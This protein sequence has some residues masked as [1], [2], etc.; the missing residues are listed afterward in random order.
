[1]VTERTPNGMNIKNLELVGD[2]AKL[3][4]K[5]NWR[6]T[7]SKSITHL[8]GTL[9]MAKADQLF[10]KLNITKDF[11]NT[12]GAIEFQLNWKASPLEL[13]I[14]N[15]QGTMDVKLK[16][17]RILSIE[18]GF[19]RVL[20]I[21]A[22]AQWIKRLQLDF[23][24][25]YEEGLTFNSIEGHFDF[26]NGKAT[27]KDLMIDAVPAKITIT[28]D[29]DL[30]NQ[31]VDHVIKV[32]PKSLDA[33]PIAGTIIS[34]IA[35]VVG[36]TLT[37]KDQEGFFFGTNYLVKGQWDNIKISSQH[38]NDGLFQKTWKGITEFPW[39]DRKK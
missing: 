13:A 31:T 10:D 29:T 4:A 11:T 14:P 3:T 6:E 16:S 8:N 9:A 21:L 5:G 30:V 37:G 22:V 36:K 19:G 2:D 26:V 39:E 33:V 35:A 28:G 18:P 17:G 24:D 27:T 25:I 38:E 23:S 32:V 1:M 12:N 15:L 20:G 7:G 34:R